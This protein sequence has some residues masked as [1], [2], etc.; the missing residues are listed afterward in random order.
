MNLSL[1]IVED[2][3]SYAIELEAMSERIGYHVIGTVDNSAEALELIY[4]ESPDLVIMDIG[5]KGRMD[6]TEIGVKVSHLGIPI[7]Y[8][9]SHKEEHFRQKA[10]STNNIGY[11][12]K[13]IDSITLETIL[14]MAVLKAYFHGKDQDV[15]ANP[16]KST[17]PSIYFKKEGIYQKVN[18]KDIVTISSEDNYC[19]TTLR[20]GSTYLLRSTLSKLK[21]LLNE[22][23]FFQI[24]R[25]HLIRLS[26]IKSVD[27]TKLEVTVI[28]QKLPI[29][30]SKVNELRNA[31][32][33]IK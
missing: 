5:I 2:S 23:D 18:T 8:L 13:P 28:S 4:S 33:F 17:N 27:F 3:L 32:R 10:L 7:L 22:P 6:G 24:H 21:T 31:F 15:V 9:T 19:K 12:I 16:Q 1:L 25:S 14:R 20:D 11:L 26:M 29:S 30:R